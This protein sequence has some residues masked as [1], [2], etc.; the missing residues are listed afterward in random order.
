MKCDILKAG[1][2]GYTQQDPD[3]LTMIS[4][5]L[6]VIP[7]SRTGAARLVEL[8]GAGKRPVNHIEMEWY[9]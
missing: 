6:C 2:H 8:A 3:L 5:E 9:T 1:H 4:P 7:N